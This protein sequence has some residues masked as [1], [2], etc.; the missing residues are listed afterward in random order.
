[1]LVYLLVLYIS[2]VINFY[3]VVVADNNIFGIEEYVVVCYISCKQGKNWTDQKLILEEWGMFVF[4]S[5]KSL[6]VLTL[7][8]TLC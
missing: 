2:L 7:Y 8:Q 4:L 1:M 6:C 5:S 3:L